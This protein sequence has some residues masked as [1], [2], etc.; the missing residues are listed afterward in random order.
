[1]PP[2]EEFLVALILDD[3]KGAADGAVAFVASAHPDVARYAPRGER[4]GDDGTLLV[5]WTR[6][7]P[8]PVVLQSHV[9]P[10][11]ISGLPLDRARVQEDS[12]TKVTVRGHEGVVRT[13]SPRAADQNMYGGRLPTVLLNWF[14]GDVLWSVQSYFLTPDEVLKVAESIRP[15]ITR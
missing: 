2:G 13:W 11:G 1:V 5:A 9:G 14:E 3:G 12:I 8:R 6:R 15:T 7:F 10:I 4:N